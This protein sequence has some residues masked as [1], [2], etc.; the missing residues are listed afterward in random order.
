MYKG[1]VM[2]IIQQGFLGTD[3]ADDFQVKSLFGWDGSAGQEEFGSNGRSDK[4]RQK[5]S[6]SEAWKPATRSSTKTFN[7]V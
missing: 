7:E 2:K 5:E 4:F 6:P 1:N 3:P